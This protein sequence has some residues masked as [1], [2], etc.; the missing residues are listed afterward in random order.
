QSG[1]FPDVV[2]IGLEGEA[3]NADPLAEKIAADGTLDH[4]RH[5]SLAGVVDPDNRLDEPD[6]CLMNLRGLDESERIL[7]KTAA[8]VARTGIEELAADTAV[9]PRAGGDVLDIGPDFLAEIGD[10][11]D[12]GEL[13]GKKGVGRVF[14]QLGAPARREDDRMPAWVERAVDLGHDW[15]GPLAVEADDHP[16]RYHEIV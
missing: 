6:R 9:E 12:I 2:G 4:A 5:G 8:A 10:F 15:P 14:R 1:R 7:R 13:Q 3:E 16:V 11:V